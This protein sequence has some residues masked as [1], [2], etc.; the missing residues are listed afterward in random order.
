MLVQALQALASGLLTGS[1][2]ALLG[3][4]FSL[5]WG[6]AHVINIAHPALAVGAAYA[7]YVLAARGVDPLMSLAVVVPFFFLLGV[8]FYE[9]VVRPA[10]RRT[11]DLMLVSMVL[12]F[13]LA[14]A[15]ENALAAAW[16]P[17]PRV[18]NVAYTGRAIR[19]GTLA[20]PV[21]HLAGA[22]LAAV[23]ITAL[24]VFLHRTF[25]GKA[26]RAVWQNR[27]GA[28]LC[29]VDL[30]RVTSLTYGLA[31]ASASVAGVALALIYS[32]SPATHLTWLVFVFL[33]VIVGGVGSLIGAVVAGML[34][35][36]VT[37]LTT[38]VIPFA[39]APFL[40]FASLGVLLLW[41]PTGLFR[42]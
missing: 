34:V 39:W 20:L 2:Y 24:Y 25:P 35:G 10:A 8:G 7:A 29:G 15:L 1:V 3:A 30:R 41:R 26:V 28:A 9:G 21:T 11:G 18:I 32:F 31:I 4:G 14:A 17:G 12:T 19:L 13:G 5:I 23:T 16:G 40:L 6:V 42:Q 37:N 36:A 33:V 38:L 27:D 22:G